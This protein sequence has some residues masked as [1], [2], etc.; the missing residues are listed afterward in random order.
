MMGVATGITPTRGWMMATT[1]D[2]GTPDEVPWW[3]VKWPQLQPFKKGDPRINRTKPGPGRPPQDYLRR[4]QYLEPKALD[5]IER[6]LRGGGLPALRA[7]VEVL[8]RLHPTPT[9]EMG[10]VLRIIIDDDGAPEVLEVQS[11]RALPEPADD[12]G[13]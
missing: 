6:V 13:E 1:D 4:L 3:K 2:S 5:T 11:T 7:A 10:S 12:K 8:Q 9:D